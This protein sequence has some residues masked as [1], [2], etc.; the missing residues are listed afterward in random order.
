[1]VV[2]FP[3]YAIGVFNLRA[4]SCG[5]AS[6]VADISSSCRFSYY[7]HLNKSADFFNIVEANFSK[8]HGVFDSKYS[9]NRQKYNQK[10]I[11][12]EAIRNIHSMI[13][14]TSLSEKILRPRRH[15]P[16]TKKA[17]TT[18]WPDQRPRVGVEVERRWAVVCPG[19]VR[20]VTSGARSQNRASNA[21]RSLLTKEWTVANNPSSSCVA[22]ACRKTISSSNHCRAR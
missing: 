8:Q 4:S 7:Q 21:R 11:S 12:C 16:K 17:K 20:P 15:S 18:C 10:Q 14:H 5:V 2:S 1:M 6:S 22:K 13:T 9:Q 19:R 3:S